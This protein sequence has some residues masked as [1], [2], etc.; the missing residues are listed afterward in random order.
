M[1]RF[2]V[3]AVFYILP[4]SVFS[5]VELDYY[6]PGEKTLPEIPTP[7][8]VIGHQ[9][10]E[11]H[12]T[13]DKLTAYLDKLAH[14]SDRVV[15]QEYARS[16]ENRPLFHLIITSPENHARLEQIRE[17]H[18]KLGDPTVSDQLDLEDMPV[19]VRLGYGVHGNESS[20]SNSSVLAAYYLAASLDQ[21]VLDYLDK[22][23]I[24]ID[25]CLN[26]DGFNRHASWINMHK[27]QT[28]V[29]DDNSRGFREVWPGGRT[30]HYWFDLNR[31]W[32]LLQ[33][34]ESR[35]RVEVFHQW[36]PNVQTDHHEMGSSSTFFFQPGIP[37][38]TN[39]YTPQGTTDLTSKIGQYH[40]RALDEIGSLYFTEEIFDDFYYGKGSSYPDVNGSIGILFEQA[41]TRGFERNTSGGKLTFPY[42]IRNQVKVSFSTLKASYEMRTELL[43]HQRDF[44]KAYSSQY[45]AATEKAYVFG[46]ADGAGTLASFID[47]LLQHRIEVYRL[48]QNH[49]ID[50]VTY[51]PAKAYVVPLNQL[52]FR[53][54]QSLFR[55]Q[56]TF[57]DSLFYDV[58]AWT[59]PYAFNIP[60]AAVNQSSLAGELKGEQMLKSDSQQGKIIGE[61]SEVGYIFRWN[62]YDAPKA[63]YKIQSAGLIT[64]VGTE[65]IAY[66]N[67]EINQSFSYGS[68]FI[69]VQQQ[70]SPPGEVYDIIDGAV[71]ETSVIAYSLGTSYTIEGM[72]MGSGRFVPLQKPEVLLLTGDGV[73]SLDAGEIW[74]L[75]DARMHMPVV[76]INQEQL[77][78]MDLSGYTHLLMPPGSYN[79]ISATGRQE[80]TRWVNKGGTIIALNTANRWLNEN[81]LTSM[82]FKANPVDSSGY[83]AYKDL[84]NNSGAQRISGSIFQAHVDISHPIG[85]GLGR[86]T[87][88]VF[89]NHSLIALPDHRP[90]AYPVRYT[91]EPLLSGYVPEEKYDELRNTPGVIINSLGSGKIISFIDNPNF[92][93]FWYGTNK[94]FMN[95]IFFGPAISS[96]STR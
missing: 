69:P 24:L 3:C 2:L 67:Q 19:V 76:L 11:W 58:S 28:P 72:D 54:V 62:E 55:P 75:L 50:G 68:I 49:T 65:P 89:R 42:A 8:S 83:K 39:P 84:R 25:P 36:R 16:W 61:V 52:Q 79:R 90:Y 12:L 74:N 33:H 81:K 32:I 45:D 37:S 14:E 7:E 26:P 4:L 40:A 17:E 96:Y 56:K 5:Q 70:E 13:H 43:E 10:G 9:V 29:A 60:Y 34:P 27:S 15:L 21:A 31:D 53:L 30:N 87:I 46:D 22:M 66:Q 86:K 93:G 6:L 95:A 23:V 51:T 94:L 80:I 77:N 1:R 59:L 85:Y 82:K 57:A 73:R 18:L 48:K 88:P 20:A 41:G 47:I 63:L 91:D 78:S 35:G 44:Y 64:Q 38:R 92:R 71:R